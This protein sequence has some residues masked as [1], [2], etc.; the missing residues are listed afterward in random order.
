MLRGRVPGLRRLLVEGGG[1][2]EVDGH[3]LPSRVHDAQHVGRLHVPLAGGEVVPLVGAAPVALHALARIGELGERE[4]RVGL[5]VHRR[6]DEAPAGADLVDRASQAACVHVAEDVGRVGVALPRQ[7]LQLLA[8]EGEGAALQEDDRFA[9]ACPLC[10]AGER[11][12]LP[13][14]GSAGGE[15]EESDQGAGAH[16]SLPQGV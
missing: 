10:L 2:A 16:G 3:V 11:P 13:R 7:G 5:S 9:N 14:R 15:H 4:L 12:V 6:G 8:R 1:A